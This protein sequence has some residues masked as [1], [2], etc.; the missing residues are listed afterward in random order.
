MAT[1]VM[2]WLEQ[3]PADYD[4][5]IE[6]LTLGRLQAL[7]EKIAKD[8]IWSTGQDEVRVL[9]LGCGTGVLAALMAREGAT[10]SAVDASQSM[11]DY[12]EARASEQGLEDDISFFLADITEIGDLF[13]TGSFDFIVSTL[14]FSELRPEVQSYVLKS[15]RELLT[16]NGRLILVDEI[17][18]D[19]FLNKLGF[20]LLRLPL[21]LITWLLT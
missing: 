6:M 14:V 8:Y 21:T 7:K 4:R 10:V 3:S 9:E 19:G 12:A 17:V 5:G 18:P 15:I 16:E 20:W 13:E 1:V 11:L 2:R